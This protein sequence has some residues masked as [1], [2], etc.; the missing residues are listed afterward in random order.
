MRSLPAAHVEGLKALTAAFS[1]LYRSMPDA[2][3]KVADQVFLNAGHE[4]AA[5]HG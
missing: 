5:T 3:K 2:Q 4:K 1:T